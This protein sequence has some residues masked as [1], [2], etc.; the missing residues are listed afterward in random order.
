L[1]N[2]Y[3]ITFLIKNRNKENPGLGKVHSFKSIFIVIIDVLQINILI[4]SAPSLVFSPTTNMKST[5][6]T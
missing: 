6:Q 1:D 2:F 3:K 4:I 5:K